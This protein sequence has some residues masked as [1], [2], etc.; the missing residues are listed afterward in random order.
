MEE[1]L[2]LFRSKLKVA[3]LESLKEDTMSPIM[4]AKKLKKPRSSISRII[5][6]LEELGWVNTKSGEKVLKKFIVQ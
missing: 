5:L 3:I 1:L 2:P 4:L 6:E